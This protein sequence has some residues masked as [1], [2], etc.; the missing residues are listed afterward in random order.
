MPN[1]VGQ[2]VSEVARL[3]EGLDSYSYYEY[4][5]VTPRSD[6]IA[7]REAFY[8]RAQ[9]FHPDR[10]VATAGESVKTA[11]Y[12]VYKRMTEAYNVLV[13]P[14]L[15]FLYDRDFQEKRLNRLAAESRARRLDADERE[16]SNP[17][18]RVY[19][20]SAK[21]KLEK[22]D[23]NGA[24]IDAELGLSLEESPPLRELHVQVIRRMA[25]R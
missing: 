17:L 6:Y 7:I 5:G 15:R 2:M 14:E 23:V 4:L 16:V 24:W 25:G 12:A 9:Q 13:D 3:Y 10:F 11:I 19:L 8:R 1:D 18:A 21:F 20:S 22:G